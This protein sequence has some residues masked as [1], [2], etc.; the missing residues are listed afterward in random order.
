MVAIATATVVIMLSMYVSQRGANAKRN[1]LKLFEAH[2]KAHPVTD[3]KYP[4]V[5]GI[6]EDVT[7]FL[8]LA[9]KIEAA[10]TN[11]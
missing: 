9:L 4:E 6:K 11:F 8:R 2:F 5:D 1:H 3:F 7:I 10:L